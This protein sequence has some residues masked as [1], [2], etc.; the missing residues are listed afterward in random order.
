MRRSQAAESKQGASRQRA[1][2]FRCRLVVMAKVPVAGR[3]KTRL[4][5]EVG[6]SR[7]V[8]FARMAGAALLGRVARD[9]R[10]ETWLAIAPDCG[11]HSRV[12]P[13]SVPRMAQGRGDLGSR[14]Q[15]I[16]AVL[17]PGPVVIVGTDIPGIRPGMIA[18][19]FA[20]LGAAD[21]VFGP[22]RDGGYWLVGLRRR[23]RMLRPFGAVRW[24]SPH[25]LSDTRANLAGA[26]S[27]M[28]DTLEDVD[29]A[30]SLRQLAWA[31]G[32]RVPGPR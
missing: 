7:A 25:A 24:S 30:A 1:A 23:P 4:A 18:R 26:R 5:R 2:P 3:V 6:T 13:Q 32:R 16:F 12:W 14:M 22:A 11:I 20:L 31:S 27:A 21:A 19:A 17:P 15:R 9:A 29:D 8:G 28:V 10:W